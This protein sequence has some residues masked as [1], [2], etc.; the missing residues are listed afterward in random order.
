MGDDATDLGRSVELALA[1]AALCGEMPHQILV[2]VAEDVIV[3]GAVFGEVERRVLE[4]TDEVFET[5]HHGVPLTQLVRV[6]EIREVATSEA[7]VGRDQWCDHF[8]VDSIAD[9]TLTFE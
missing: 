4:D 5:L 2:R 1:L 6:V 9:I 8:F 3:F 7:R